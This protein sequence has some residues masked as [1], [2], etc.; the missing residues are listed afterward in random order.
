MAST[1]K[2]P[3]AGKKKES[4]EEAWAKSEAKR[5]LRDDIISG[6]VKKT[7]TPK[8]VH[9]SRAIFQRYELS[10]FRTNLSNLRDALARDFSRMLEDCQY[11]GHDAD[12]LIQHRK[13][14]PLLRTPWHLHDAK[15]LLE[16]DI[17]DRLHDKLAP[18]ELRKTRPE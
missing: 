9:D 6:R 10:K 17:T 13:K 18:S 14:Y 8:E 16:K 7:M 4:E 5:V 11:Y 1:A 2:K 15:E 3:A 12:V